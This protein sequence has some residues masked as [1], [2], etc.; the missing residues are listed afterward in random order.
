M[1]SSCMEVNIHHGGALGN[2]QE[3]ACQIQSS[4]RDGCFTSLKN[5]LIG[6]SHSCCLEGSAPEFQ[7]DFLPEGTS[8]DVQVNK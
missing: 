1:Q 2:F 4:C 6:D 7:T 3:Q 8:E 5:N